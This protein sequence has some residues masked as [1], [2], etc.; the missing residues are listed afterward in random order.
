MRVVGTFYGPSTD[1]PDPTLLEQLNRL[2][3]LKE[4]RDYGFW[5]LRVPDLNLVDQ[6]IALSQSHGWRPHIATE[7]VARDD[8][9]YFL[10]YEREYDASD[11][12]QAE[13]LRFIGRGRVHLH[14]EGRRDWKRRLMLDMMQS[15]IEEPDLIA[16]TDERHMLVADPVL[17]SLRSASLSGISFF[18][19][20]FIDIRDVHALRLPWDYWKRRWW[21]VIGG[22]L[23]LPPLSHRQSIVGWLTREPLPRGSDQPCLPLDVDDTRIGTAELHYERS[24]I[25]TVEPFDFAHTFERIGRDRAVIVSQRFYQAVK[26]GGDIGRWVPVRVHD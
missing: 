14:Q 18:E 24:D 12:E 21:E 3:P 5:I 11:Y 6:A 15:D 4:R 13:Y 22:N 19:T 16:C 23:V 10:D 7:R 9:V 8:K 17:E 1:R 2:L 25:R 20:M 26:T